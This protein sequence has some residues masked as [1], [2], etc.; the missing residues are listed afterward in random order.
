VRLHHEGAPCRLF[1]TTP[2]APL[3][4]PRM[5]DGGQRDEEDEDEEHLADQRVLLVRTT[6]TDAA[7]T[8]AY[9]LWTWFLAARQPAHPAAAAAPAAPSSAPA[10]GRLVDYPQ[11]IRER[12]DA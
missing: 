4:A 9:Q 12:G 2:P 8:L 6:M 5:Q 11:E 7:L 3:L 1:L 10:E